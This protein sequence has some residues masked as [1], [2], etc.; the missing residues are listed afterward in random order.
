MV[1]MIAVRLSQVFFLSVISDMHLVDSDR[2]RI[3]PRGMLE[4][5][6]SVTR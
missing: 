6:F 5:R 4:G 1:S 2:D 3:D